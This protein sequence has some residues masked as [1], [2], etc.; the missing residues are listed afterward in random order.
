MNNLTISEILEYAREDFENSR[1]TS[2]HS[3]SSILNNA[4]S[5]I[6]ASALIELVEV[7]DCG[8]VGGF[9][10]GYTG[11]RSLESRLEWLE[12]KYQE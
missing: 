9:G 6:K 10:Q 2:L 1:A 12:R 11:N 7:F 5:L 3:T 8:S 4:E